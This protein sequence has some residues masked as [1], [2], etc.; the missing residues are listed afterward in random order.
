MIDGIQTYLKALGWFDVQSQ[1]PS[2]EFPRDVFPVLILGKY[3]YALDMLFDYLWEPWRITVLASNPDIG[4]MVWDR[5]HGYSALKCA[6]LRVMPDKGFSGY[7]LRKCQT[8]QDVEDLVSNN[9]TTLGGTYAD[10]T[11][12]DEGF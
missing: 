5:M 11:R 6:E 3:N 12:S 8:R 7:K 9:F 1:K 4:E 10:T 2:N